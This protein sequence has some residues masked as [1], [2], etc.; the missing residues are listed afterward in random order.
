MVSAQRVLS[1]CTV[2]FGEC[3]MSLQLSIALDR[4]DR[5]F[6][7][8]DATVVPPKGV[9][10]HVLQVGQTVQLRDGDFRHERMIR[11]Q[12]FDVCEFSFS[13]YLMAKDRGLPLT[14]VPV[15]PRRL[16]SAGLFYVLEGS[17]IRGPQD[18]V[19]RRVGLNSFQTTLSVLARGDLKKEYGVPWE[20]VIWCVINAEKVTFK[21]RA[22]VSIEVLPAGTDLGEALARGQIDAFIH[23]HPPHSVTTGSVRARRLFS[24]AREEEIRYF[25]KYGYFP[26]MHVVALRPSLISSHPHVPRLVMDLFAQANQISSTYYDDPNWSRMVFGRH[27]FEEDLCLAGP[28]AWPGGVRRNA[29][30]VADFVEYMLDQNLISKKLSPEELFAESVLD[31]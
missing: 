8:F 5:H 11:D 19:G 21:A 4:Y 1:M 20:D 28:D 24:H 14:A 9:T 29:K 16:F 15:F 13:S 17:E 3:E 10:L 2:D 30:N 23:P 18:L 25:H 6:P 7:F 26:I 12:E 22:G 27:Y 31:T